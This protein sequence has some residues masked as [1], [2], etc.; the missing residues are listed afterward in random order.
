M[1]KELDRSADTNEALSDF[2]LYARQAR[3]ALAARGVV[4]KELYTRC[5]RVNDGERIEVFRPGSVRNIGYYFAV[6]GKKPHVQ[7]GVMTSDDLIH[8]AERYFAADRPTRSSQ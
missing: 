3:P 7:Y 4:F 1:Q 2:Q 8:A 6:P 5:F